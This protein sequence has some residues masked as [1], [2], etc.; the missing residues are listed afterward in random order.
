METRLLIFSEDFVDENVLIL[1]NLTDSKLYNLMVQ[2]DE[3][4]EHDRQ[5]TFNE[6]LDHFVEC[7]ILG[8]TADDFITV[9]T[10]SPNELEDVKGEMLCYYSCF[11]FNKVV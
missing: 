10:E 4:R 2:F 11:Q 6:I 1:T 5:R 9:F 7:E 8:Y 3:D